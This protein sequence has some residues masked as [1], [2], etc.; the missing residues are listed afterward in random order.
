MGMKEGK[1]SMN[2]ERRGSKVGP[3]CG[4]DREFLM[5]DWKNWLFSHSEAR[6]SKK[7]KSKKIKKKTKRK[8]KRR[9][10]KSKS[11]KYKKKSKQRNKNIL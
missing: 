6:V 9:S 3:N 1:Y 10:K 2:G 11:I 4:N 5:G 7:K 8:I